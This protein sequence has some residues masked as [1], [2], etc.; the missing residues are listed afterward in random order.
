MVTKYGLMVGG[1]VCLSGM[2]WGS[3]RAEDQPAAAVKVHPKLARMDWLA[4]HWSLKRG[5]DTLEEVWAAPRGDA[6]MGM[7]RW[8]KQDKTWIFELCTI[9]IEGEDVFFRLRH[10]GSPK[11]DAWEEKDGAITLKMVTQDADQVIFQ[12]DKHDMPKILIIKKTADGVTIRMEGVREGKPVGDEFAYKKLE[13][14]K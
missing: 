7:F 5:D 8:I 13:I 1:M 12:S 9:S 6:M 11:L 10:F 4:G 14:R 2:W 3:V